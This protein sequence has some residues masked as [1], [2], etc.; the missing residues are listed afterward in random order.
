MVE[1]TAELRF[2]PRE[3]LVVTRC[4]MVTYSFRSHSFIRL[5]ECVFLDRLGVENSWFLRFLGLLSF[6]NALTRILAFL[7]LHYA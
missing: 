6:L 7:T 2:E 1:E 5:I 3:G 4:L